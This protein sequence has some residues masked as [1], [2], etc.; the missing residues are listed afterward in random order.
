MCRY[1]GDQL[2]IKVPK[3]EYRILA[4]SDYYV[5]QILFQINLAL[6]LCKQKVFS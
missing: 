6:Y 4:S 5:L 2:N 1:R 3:K